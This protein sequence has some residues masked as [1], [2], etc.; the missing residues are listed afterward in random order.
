MQ[1]LPPPPKG[2]RPM[3][4]HIMINFLYWLR[5]NH[6]KERSFRGASQ[7]KLLSLVHEFERNRPDIQLLS[8]QQWLRSFE[9]LEKE[10]DTQ[11]DYLEVKELY[12][13]MQ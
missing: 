10:D 11:S 6:P 12:R 2:M 4:N 5:T 8:D 9:E 13:K 7:E 1:N 3:P